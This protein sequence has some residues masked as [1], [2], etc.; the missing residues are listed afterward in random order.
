[1]I[2]AYGSMTPNNSLQGESNFLNLPVL[3][4]RHEEVALR[5]PTAQTYRAAI[6]H[7]LGIGTPQNVNGAVEITQVQYPDLHD[8]N[9]MTPEFGAELERSLLSNV[10]LHQG[11]SFGPNSKVTRAD[12]AA[13]LLRAGTVPQYMRAT[14]DVYGCALMQRPATRSRAC[15]QILEVRCSMTRQPAVGSIRTARLQDWSP[16]SPRQSSGPRQRRRDRRPA[17]QRHRWPFDT[18]TVARLCGCCPA[19]WISLSRRQPVSTPTKAITRLELARA[20]NALMQ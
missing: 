10:M 9:G 1:M 14:P 3:T 19:A 15:S 16:P 6:D 2:L 8:L 5:N 20:V 17:R 13:T 18:V 4:G 11:H 7:T 12:L